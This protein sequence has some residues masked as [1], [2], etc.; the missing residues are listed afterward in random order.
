MSGF[1]DLAGRIVVIT[2]ASSGIGRAATVAFAGEGA[3]LVLAARAL[4]PLEQLAGEC[5]RLGTRAIA[6]STDVRDESAVQ[7][8]AQRAVDEFGRI[9]VWVNI[10]GVIAYGRFEEIPSDIFRAVLECNLHGQIH[11][12]RAALK[13]FRGNERGVLINMCSVWGRVTSPDVSAYVASKFAV[14]AFSQCL[15]LE[16]SD[17][18]NISVATMLPQAVDTPIFD[19]AA[20]MRGRPVRPIPPLVAPEQVAA[21]IVQCARSPKA[22]VTWARAGRALELAY[23]LTPRLFM[24]FASGAFA[25]GSFGRGTAPVSMGNLLQSTVDARSISGGWRAHRQRSLARALFAA[26]TGAVRGKLSD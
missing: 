2:G 23:T 21:G 13:E 10:A 20:N 4:E 24:R 9:D 3:H 6:V 11:G 8:L 12:A 5:E 17:S 14:R 26:T 19:H 25:A 16:L 18:P 7:A 1:P 22:E 15:R